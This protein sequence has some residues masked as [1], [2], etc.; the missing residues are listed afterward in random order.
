MDDI[1]FEITDGAFEYLING[2]GPGD[3]LIFPAGSEPSL[4][5]DRYNDQSV[6]LEWGVS[7]KIMRLTFTDISNDD[8]LNSVSDFN[9]VFGSGTFSFPSAPV[10]VTPVPPV[11]PV[12]SLN[13]AINATGS[14]TETSATNTTFTVATVASNYTYTIAGFGAG[15]KIVGP[16]GI[17]PTFPNTN[18]IDGNATLQYASGNF[19]VLVTLTGLTNAQDALLTTKLAFDTMFGANTLT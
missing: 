1:R 13:K 7:G 5:N 8:Q 15:D 16:S 6:V 4:F 9:T 18:F 17:T 14:A 19:K 2:F 12:T 3:T 10:P 11:P